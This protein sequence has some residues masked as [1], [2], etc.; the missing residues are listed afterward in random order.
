MVVLLALAGLQARA[1]SPLDRKIAAAGQ[2]L[3]CGRPDEGHPV[4]IG[5]AL[6]T[7]GD[8]IGVIVKVELAP[9]WHIYDYVPPSLPYIPIDTVLKLPAGVR[10]VGS[11][12]KSAPM[13]SANDPGV[14]IYEGE[15]VFV[16]KVVRGRGSGPAGGGTIQAGLYYQTCNL[17]QCL[18]PVE[19][20]IELT[21]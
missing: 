12:I 18:P 14:L 16:H 4:S 9:G 2:S 8:S 13:A 15:A 6:V 17:R 11:W 5:A 3:Q 20:T 1:Q 21:F 19:T 10:G 7:E